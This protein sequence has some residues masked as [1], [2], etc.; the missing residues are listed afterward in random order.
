MEISAAFRSLLI[1]IIAQASIQMLQRPTDAPGATPGPGRSQ[2]GKVNSKDQGGSV[3]LLQIFEHNVIPY[4]AGMTKLISS[5]ATQ[6]NILFEWLMSCAIY[7]NNNYITN[8]QGYVY[9][10]YLAFSCGDSINNLSTSY[11]HHSR[12][13]NISQTKTLVKQLKPSVKVSGAN[14]NT[15]DTRVGDYSLSL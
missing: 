7:H 2:F 4:Q 11:P 9:K 3:S 13:G 6:N 5:V 8:I 1:L 14:R 12:R 10:E 15:L